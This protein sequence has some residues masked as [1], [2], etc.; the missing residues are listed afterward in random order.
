MRLLYAEVDNIKPDYMLRTESLFQ[1]H[2]REGQGPGLVTVDR[3]PFVTRMLVSNKDEIFN[4][5]ASFN[6]LQMFKPWAQSD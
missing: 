2:D 5:G 4:Y 1:V 3:Q 6:H